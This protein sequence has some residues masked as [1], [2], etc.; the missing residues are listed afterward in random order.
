MPI[1]LDGLDRFIARFITCSYGH[2][3]CHLKSMSVEE[4]TSIVS[5]EET[6]IVLT[7]E[8]K[9]NFLPPYRNFDTIKYNLL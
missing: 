6:I 9:F 7:T 5:N 4:H 1:F 3:L 8:Q 2:S